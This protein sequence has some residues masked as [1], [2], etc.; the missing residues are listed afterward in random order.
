MPSG[1]TQDRESECN[2]GSGPLMSGDVAALSGE[3]PALRRIAFAISR[4]GAVEMLV[5][6]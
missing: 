4:N 5:R 6:K 2:K 3:Q 1:G